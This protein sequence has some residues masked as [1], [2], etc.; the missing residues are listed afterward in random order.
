MGW[1]AAV[2]FVAVLAASLVGTRLVLWL[3]RRRSILDLPNERSSH[4]VA[5]PRGVATRWSPS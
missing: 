3:L 5:T 1:L 2:L 4:R